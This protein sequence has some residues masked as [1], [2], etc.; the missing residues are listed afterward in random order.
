VVAS[1]NRV[2]FLNPAVGLDST[3]A[4]AR[5]FA[6]KSNTSLV[7]GTVVVHGALRSASLVTGRVSVISILAQTKR[8]SLRGHFADGVRAAG[9]GETRADGRPLAFGVWISFEAMSAEALL[10]VSGNVAVSIWSTWAR[11]AKS[12]D[13]LSAASVRVS[14]SVDRAIAVW[15]AS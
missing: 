9:T 2:V 8:L 10:L 6:L 13:R 4:R 7:V 5:I 14:N 11:L 12:S 3:R 1:T 15:L